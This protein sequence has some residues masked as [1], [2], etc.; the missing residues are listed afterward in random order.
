VGT[1]ASIGVGIGGPDVLPRPHGGS[2][3]EKIYRGELGGRDL[4]GA[5]IAGFSVQTPELG[6]HSGNFT[7][8][9]LFAHCVGQNQCKYI[10]WA[11]NTS[12]GGPKQRWETGILPFIRAHPSF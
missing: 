9:E 3:G 8:A 4:R 7:P 12:V 2:K 11:R 5:M 1:L 10:F 6:G